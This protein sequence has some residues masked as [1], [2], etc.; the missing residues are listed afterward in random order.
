MRS[1]EVTRDRLV[2]AALELYAERGYAGTCLD[3][4][5]QR[6]VS[7]KGAFYYHFESKEHLTALALTVGWDAWMEEIQLLWQRPGLAAD[8]LHRLLQL[9][10]PNDNGTAGCALGMLGFE[11][12]SLPSQVQQVL[13]EGL[14]RWQGLLSRLLHELGVNDVQRAAELAELLFV[15][16]QGGVLIQRVNGSNGA[17]TRALTTWRQEVLEALG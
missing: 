6:A 7:S 3:A 15:M 11:S 16:Y 17:L 10:K 13:A 1:A 8:K 9:L 5:L 14:Q 12:S 4:I 2:G